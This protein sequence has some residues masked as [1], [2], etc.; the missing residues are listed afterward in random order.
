ME[1]GDATPRLAVV[2]LSKTFGQFRALD[3]V[4]LELAA[5]EIHGLVGQNGSG[6]ST[7]VKV[8][9][10]VHAP[11]RGATITLD[12]ARLHVPIRARELA[13]HGIAVVHQDLGLVDW[14][15]ITDNCRVGHFAAGRISRRVDWKR[16]HE[17]VGE[18]LARLGCNLDPRSPVGGLTAADRTTVAIARA[19]QDQIPG[20]GVILLDEATRTLPRPAQARLYRLIGDFAASG[21]SVLLISH[22]VDEVLSV[23]SRV[24]VLRDGRIVAGS[25]ATADLDQSALGQLLVGRRVD[26]PPSLSARSGAA[27]RGTDVAQTTAARIE[28]LVGDELDRTSF[29]IA[30]G[31]VL[32]VTGLIGSGVGELPELITGARRA[33]SGR[34]KLPGGSIDLSRRSLHKCLD[35]GVVLVP[36]FRDRDGLALSLS[37]ADNLALPL[38][39]RNSRFWRVNRGW[40]DD[41]VATS[42]ASLQITPPSGEQAV[43]RLSGGN[44]QKVL[45]G[46]WL[47]TSPQVLVLH[48]PTQGVDVGARAQLLAL[49]RQAAASGVAIVMA[50]IEAE[51]LAAVCDRVLILQR[52]RIAAELRAP[53]DVDEIVERTYGTTPELA[54]APGA[55]PAGVDR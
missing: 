29:T 22:R 50:T 32:G 21:G 13:R 41:L 1:Q 37:V 11:D 3:D 46:K 9:A 31:E 23:A 42:I 25:V 15:S 49:I 39:R 51:D 2:G 18:V 40:E 35:G 43:G 7:L 5:G 14:L 20:R 33:I 10:G 4:S 8:L 36:E 38:L 24:S 19:I 54:S 48:E 30:A 16:E 34:L 44:R 45:F 6:K 53:C 27:K 47:A 12:G 55:G 28:D 17:R 26:G 52:G